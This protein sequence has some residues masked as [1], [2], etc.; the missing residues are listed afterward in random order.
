MVKSPDIQ[1][2]FW[3][4]KGLDSS[5]APLQVLAWVPG[6]GFFLKVILYSQC[7][8][9]CPWPTQTSPPPNPPH[10]LNLRPVSSPA[11]HNICW[12]HGF[13]SLISPVHSV[14]V[15]TLS[16]HTRQD[17]SR[18]ATF[19]SRSHQHRASPRSSS[20]VRGYLYSFDRGFESVPFFAPSLPTLS[21]NTPSHPLPKRYR[22]TVNWPPSSRNL[23]HLSSRRPA[24]QSLIPHVCRLDHFQTSCF[25]SIRPL[26]Y[27]QALSTNCSI[28]KA[29]TPRS[30]LRHSKPQ[31]IGSSWTDEPE[32]TRRSLLVTFALF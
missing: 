8:S 6:P 22:T 10:S 1:Y 29:L 19:E 30:T 24:F 15:Q 4:P 14:Q 3:V 18:I 32:H 17:N 28:G 13:P 21:P 20:S 27:L 5:V 7:P 9:S 12:L 26:K 23:S 31:E 16:R 2:Q 25:F 11:P